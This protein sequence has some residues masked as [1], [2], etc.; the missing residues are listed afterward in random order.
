MGELARRM[1]PHI[2]K[3]TLM[4]D[5]GSVKHALVAELE[6]IFSAFGAAYIGSHPMAGSEKTGVAAAR[7]DLF[8]NAACVVTPTSSS[9]MEKVEET[10]EL[11]SSVGGRVIRLS[12]EVHDALVAR[13]S[14]LPHVIAAQLA[15]LVLGR[16]GAP[17]QQKLCASGFR[18]STRI[19][20]GSP[21]MWRD[22]AIM[23]RDHLISALHDFTRE[24]SG[25][26]EILERND[27]AA[28]EAFF[29]EAKTLRDNWAG[30]CASS[31]PE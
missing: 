26:R 16:R 3:N 23:N 7:S 20:S 28:L 10:E 22:I 25:F 6:P 12:P 13:S 27:L 11:W 1:A 14:H 4:T 19:A 24:L 29:Q 9:P 30:K 17:A 15:T 2:E 31:S 18:D 21:E 8:A 5:V